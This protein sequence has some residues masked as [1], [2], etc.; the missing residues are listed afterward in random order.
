MHHQTETPNPTK[1][2]FQANV[3]R[4]DMAAA[5]ATYLDHKPAIHE[6][7]RMCDNHAVAFMGAY[8]GYQQQAD[9]GAG[10]WLVYQARLWLFFNP[11]TVEAEGQGAQVR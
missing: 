6:Q 5:V 11:Q 2:T 9:Y 4:D 7:A 10:A 3:S 8:L 1:P